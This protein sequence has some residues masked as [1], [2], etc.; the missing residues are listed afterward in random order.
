[1]RDRVFSA[2]VIAAMIIWIVFDSYG[3]ISSQGEIRFWESKERMVSE[4]L[5]ACDLRNE[6]GILYL[7]P[8]DASYFIGAN[9]SCRYSSPL[10]I[11]R[12]NPPEYDLSAL[13][14]YREEYSCIMGYQGDY[15]VLD[16]L[17]ENWLQEDVPARQPIMEMI[18][19]NY[20]LVWEKGFRIL[21][22]VSG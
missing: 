15:I 22:R 14:Q 4:M 2:L 16:A 7:D 5:E 10:M 20:T 18:G 11:A 1:M 17:P 9:S 3:G 19:R 21:R 8:G 13:E 12:H 6:S